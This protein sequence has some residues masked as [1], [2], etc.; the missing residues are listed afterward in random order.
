[1]IE[2]FLT[3]IGL[4][5]V[6]ST[7]IVTRVWTTASGLALIIGIS[8]FLDPFE[9]G[10][11]FLFVSMLAAQ[12]L[13]ELGLSFTLSQFTSH[14]F[15]YVSW[16]K[17]NLL[18][19]KQENV[20]KVFRI[21]KFALVWYSIIGILMLAIIFPVGIFF[22]D[23]TTN[24]SIFDKSIFI[25][26]GVYVITGSINIIVNSILALIES[27][28]RVLEIARVRFLQAIFSTAFIFTTL[29]LG[30]GVYAL[31][32]GL[33]GYIIIGIIW[34]SFSYLN[35]L[36]QT[37]QFSAEIKLIFK[38]IIPMQWRIAISW[39]FGYLTFYT[40]T[41]MIFYFVGGVESGKY[42]M[43]MQIFTA[44]NSLGI[45]WITTKMPLFCEL[46]ALKKQK[47]LYK[48]FYTSLAQSTCVM[49]AINL[50]VIFIVNIKLD[51]FI[52]FASRILPLKL[53]ILLCICS[54]VNH[55]IF[56]IAA[57][58]RAQKIEPMLVPTVINGI[59][60]IGIGWILIPIYG[61]S[62][63]VWVYT[64]CTFIGLLAAFYIFYKYKNFID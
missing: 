59:A 52:H 5:A 16:T 61:I 42:G 29:Y 30:G 36:K 27:T 12:V 25:A 26:W 15:A 6:T 10:V 40:F 18:E 53:I 54:I 31:A 55:L 2:L 21:F 41:P 32:S 38:E 35:F 46:I 19:G 56:S 4:D 39:I 62:G 28:G 24:E 8:F 34:L 43:S 47:K 3:K 63:A 49:I 11:Y 22:I 37:L 64:L 23:S 13:L 9:Q 33:F 17:T 1:M 14:E 7:T 45:A 57:V 48:V 51:L 60:M 20:F 58:I 50:M 44:L